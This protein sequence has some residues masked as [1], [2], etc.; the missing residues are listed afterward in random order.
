MEERELLALAKGHWITTLEYA[1]QDDEYLYLVMEYLAGGNLLNLLYKQTL[2]HGAVRFYAA[3]T[4]LGVREI[5][6]LGFVYRFVRGPHALPCGNR[7]C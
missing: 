1:F 2:D 6:N 5:H 7:S 4:V 3:E